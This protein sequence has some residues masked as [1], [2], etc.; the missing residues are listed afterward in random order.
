MR[1]LVAA[2]AMAGFDAWRAG[3]RI[4]GAWRSAGAEV[5]L[6]PL[7]ELGPSWRSAQENLA[8]SDN[9]LF[10]PLDGHDHDSGPMLLSFLAGG[11]PSSLVDAVGTA[12]PDSRA[13]RLDLGTV[14]AHLAERPLVGLC[15]SGE[16]DAVLAGVRGLAG[17]RTDLPLSRRLA[18]DR[19]LVAWADLLASGGAAPTA[20]PDGAALAAAPG[21]GA[22]GGAGVVVLAL[23]GRVLTGPEALGE[24]AD[25]DRTIAAADLVVTGCDEFDVDVWGGPV[26]AHVVARAN[27]AGRPVV[28]IA[29]TNRTSLAGQREHGIEAVHA[30]GDGDITDGCL[31]FARSWFW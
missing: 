17:A 28:V 6:V 2:G 4:G 23:G 31:S 16:Q 9:T 7:A 10:V 1:V 25:L 3:A 5:A 18:L 20:P 24:I 14:R 21:S 12:G 29:R 8:G 19:M 11:G 26:V 13:Q 30:V 22:G 27:A 15:R